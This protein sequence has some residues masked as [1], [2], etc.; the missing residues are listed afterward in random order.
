MHSRMSRRFSYGT[1]RE[2]GQPSSGLLLDFMHHYFVIDYYILA[3][4]ILLYVLLQL[5]VQGEVL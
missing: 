4:M 3:C 1:K 2:K 5:G